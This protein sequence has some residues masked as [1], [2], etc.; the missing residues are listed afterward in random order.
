[1]LKLVRIYQGATVYKGDDVILLHDGMTQE[2]LR[3][4]KN[5]INEAVED[6]ID[7]NKKRDNKPGVQ[8]PDKP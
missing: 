5:I 7:D 4:L 2:E 6:I 8:A 3:Q 1:M